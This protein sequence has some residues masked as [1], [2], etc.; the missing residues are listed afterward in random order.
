MRSAT[1]NYPPLFVCAA[2][3]S[4]HVRVYVCTCACGRVSKVRGSPGRKRPKRREKDRPE[5]RR[6]EP[7]PAA[8]AGRR[9]GA[10]PSRVE[11]VSVG[12]PPMTSS[13]PER[14]NIASQM[15]LGFK[16]T[17]SNML[18][19]H[20]H[21]YVHADIQVHRYAGAH[22]HAHTHART[23]TRT[24]THINIYPNTGTPTLVL[25]LHP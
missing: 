25:L 6:R 18:S 11:S 16:A 13:H 8:P 14:L 19:V 23:Y 22:T 20:T 24:R 15:L 9:G 3:P 10:R 5:R 1:L 12:Q 17:F 2:D 21:P 7:P 4:V